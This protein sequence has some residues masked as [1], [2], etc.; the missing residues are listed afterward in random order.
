MVQVTILLFLFAG[1]EDFEKVR[2]LCFIH[3]H[4]ISLDIFVKHK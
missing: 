4:T 2:A 3:V 1:R